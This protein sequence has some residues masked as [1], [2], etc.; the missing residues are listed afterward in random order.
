M[1]NKENNKQQRKQKKGEIERG[2]REEEKL[3]NKIAFY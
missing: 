1:L 3:A 2:K